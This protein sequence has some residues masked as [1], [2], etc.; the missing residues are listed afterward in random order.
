MNRLAGVTSDLS[1]PWVFYL[2]GMVVL[3]GIGATVHPGFYA[4]A[5]AGLLFDR[6]IAWYYAG[7]VL[8][9]PPPSYAEQGAVADAT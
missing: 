1:V 8:A 5:V 9:T 6:F 7:D 2:S 4:L 3:A